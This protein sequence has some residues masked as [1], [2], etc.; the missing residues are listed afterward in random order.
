MKEMLSILTLAC[1]TFKLQNRKY[2]SYLEA[3]EAHV[4]MLRSLPPSSVLCRFQFN[5]EITKLY[6]LSVG[7]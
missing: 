6:T 7:R 1:N 4:F 3:K 2:I 5:F